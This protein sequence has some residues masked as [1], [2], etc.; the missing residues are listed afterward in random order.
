MNGSAPTPLRR[1][2]VLCRWPR[3]LAAVTAGVAA[4]LCAVG[5]MALAAWLITRAA[6]QPALSALSLAIVGVR[7]CALARGAFRYLERLAGHDAALRAV[8]RL[9][10]EVFRARLGRAALR[11]GDALSRLV[12]D[13]DSVQEL[14]LRCLFP[15]LVALVVGTGSVLACTAV[16]PDAGPVLAGGLLVAAVVLPAFAVLAHRRDRSAADRA[17]LSIAAADL[18]DGARE[19]AAFGAVPAAVSRAEQHAARMRR[20]DGESARSGAALLAGGVVV[21]GMT[22]VAVTWTALLAGQPQT[23]AAVVGFLALAAFETVLPLADAARRWA[24]HV[25]ALRRITELLAAPP[26]SPP[27]ANSETLALR[28]VSVHY[29]RPALDSAD[30]T[31]E[32]GRAVAVVGASGAGKSTLLGVLAGLVPPTAGHLERPE[33]RAVTQDAHVFST[34]IRDNLLLAAPDAT[35]SE[36]ERAAEQAGLLD[37]IRR[38]PAGF[39][40][41]VGESGQPLSGGQRQRL[42]LA[43]ALLAEPDVLLLDEPTEALEPEL[44][45]EILTRVLRARTGRSTV[46]V[47]HR[48]A[49]LAEFDEILVLDAGRIVQRG[50]HRELVAE[51]GPFRDQWEAEALT[52][53]SSRP[54]DDLRRRAAALTGRGV[55]DR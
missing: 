18:V 54:Q 52:D 48:L 8:A 20:R 53:P 14:L 35:E 26:A 28:G 41:F 45:D 17:D 42:L 27:P 22:A 3:L 37:W 29:D 13:V 1:V 44:A 9:R 19:L 40:T 36:L 24:E 21:Q 50:P 32:P 2:L 55:R 10:P 33:T 12:S 49:R 16:V 43:R 38:Q 34:T 39:G 25:P 6:E 51:P 7:A 47:T 46:V 4:E 30:L 15:A 11:D 31:V 23:S 5:L